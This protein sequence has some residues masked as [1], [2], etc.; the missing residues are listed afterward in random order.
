MWDFQ[1]VAA[2]R[3]SSLC[4]ATF[5][6]PSPASAPRLRAPVAGGR[7]RCA[8]AEGPHRRRR[9]RCPLGGPHRNRGRPGAG[10]PRTLRRGSDHG[11]GRRFQRLY[12]LQRV[13]LREPP[14]LDPR[15]ASRRHAEACQAGGPRSQ[16]PTRA[17]ED[18][19]RPAAAGAGG[20][21]AGGDARGAVVRG[22]GPHVRGDAAQHGRGH[23]HAPW[24]GCGARPCR[25]TPPLRPTTTAVR[26][27]ISA[28]A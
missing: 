17:A 9:S 2:S 24:A 16:L 1:T 23:S 26:W 11:T 15:A 19:P 22:R 5:L 27:S 12:P 13:Q 3:R 6:R 8:G 28:A 20:G 7:P 25:P 18:R 10:R 4:R 14:G 21:P